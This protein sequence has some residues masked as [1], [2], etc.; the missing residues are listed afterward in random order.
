M[1][2]DWFQPF[3]GPTLKPTQTQTITKPASTG[4]GGFLK[5]AAVGIGHPF[6]E[7]GKAVTSAPA[8]ISREIQNKPVNDI[9]Q[10]VFG[11]TNSGKIAEKILG[12]TAQVGLTAAP[13][14]GEAGAAAEGA[15]GAANA[16]KPSILGRISS[17]AIKNAP[18]GAAFGA[19]SALGQ[20]G[21]AHDVLKGAEGGAIAG[22]LTGGALGL[23]G[24]AGD[25][26]SGRLASRAANKATAQEAADNLDALKPYAGV[27][28]NHNIDELT[29]LFKNTFKTDAA[30][31]NVQNIVK[32]LTGDNGF[33]NGTKRQIL[34]NAGPVDINDLGETVKDAIN[35]SENVGALG[36][37]TVRNTAGNNLYNSVLNKIQAIYGEDGPSTV[38]N[39]SGDATI[40][41]GN[42]DA[43]NVFDEIQ[44]TEKQIANIRGTGDVQQATKSVLTAYKS[45]L[46][47]R[48][49]KTPGVNDAIKNFTVAPEDEAAFRDAVTKA[50]LPNEVADYGVNA[51]NNSKSLA[52]IRATEAPLVRSSQAANDASNYAKGTG[53]IKD[54]QQ[55]VKD[56]TEKPGRFNFRPMMTARAAN[57][58]TYNPAIG[59]PLL[60][61][62]GG[63]S[64]LNGATSLA[65]N[66]ANAL[67]G[68]AGNVLSS[69]LPRAAG[70]AEGTLGGTTTQTVQTPQEPS[71]DI[72]S[73]LGAQPSQQPSNP[74]GI[75]SDQV[76][77]L[78]LQDLAKNGGKNYSQLNELNTVLKSME[79]T[80]TPSASQITRNA[81]TNSAL[82]ALVDLEKSFSGTNLTGNPL[83]TLLGH[84]P[85]GAK[86]LKAINN[87]SPDV[88]ELVG[89]ASGSDA[90]SIKMQL[91]TTSDSYSQAKAK[92]EKLKQDVLDYQSQ[93]TD[94][95]AQPALAGVA[96]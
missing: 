58:A 36:N 73:P 83:S 21:S 47:D 53:L 66:A 18:V 25:A 24:S 6:H 69:L 55:A 92:L 60:T 42:G 95:A 3:S 1:N 50:G 2:N 54:A 33:I 56:T 45:A 81:Q 80:N 34:G 86:S 88:A 87:E 68:N 28:K 20:G 26:A 40:N 30:P 89:K 71:P 38:R 61:Y 27:A 23:L 41:M 48:L 10:N 43:N 46:M 57:M 11:T 13:F 59:V 75:T 72:N 74:L 9:Q 19:T 84:S 5:R 77:Q 44:A 91:P 17:G 8:A 4:V 16:A 51:I 52:D 67:S 49:S 22:G 65:G 90:S 63:K 39:G 31:E 85:V 79:S 62:L 76:Q 29:G 82:G 14:A 94:N 7:L 96:Q 64:V 93:F 35:S 70:A 12:D 15:E 78:M 37:A 32:Q